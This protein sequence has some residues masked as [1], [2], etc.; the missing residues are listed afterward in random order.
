VYKKF[1]CVGETARCPATIVDFYDSLVFI[2]LLL[3]R[4][5]PMRH[6]IDAAVYTSALMAPIKDVASS[7][8]LRLHA[9]KLITSVI[10][11][12]IQM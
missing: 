6:S 9:A 8:P 7:S 10:H 11:P 12:H 5:I 2:N 1:N 4:N 3:A